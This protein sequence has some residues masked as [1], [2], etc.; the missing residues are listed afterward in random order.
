M[1]LL[2][3]W[4][5]DLCLA[6]TTRECQF[7]V[8]VAPATLRKDILHGASDTI[9]T[10]YFDSWDES[11]IWRSSGQVHVSGTLLLWPRGKSA[12]CQGRCRC[13]R[14]QTS[15]VLPG[16]P[17][18]PAIALRVSI[19]PSPTMVCIAGFQE[20][21]LQ[22]SVLSAQIRLPNFR[23]MWWDDAMHKLAFSRSRNGWGSSGW[24]KHV[25]HLKFAWLVCDVPCQTSL[26]FHQ[27]GDRWVA[28]S[29]QG[30]G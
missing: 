16:M 20:F 23:D 14:W 15:V 13:C 30:Q 19:R 17:L 18:R 2:Q 10:W 11:N 29:Q 6:W 21:T 8:T 1:I 24:L 25:M 3:K 9:W 27:G 5:V 7:P 26:F 28:E 12:R 22:C 4:W